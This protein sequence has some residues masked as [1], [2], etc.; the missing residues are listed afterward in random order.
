MTPIDRSGVNVSVRSTFGPSGR[1]FR[2]LERGSAK[3]YDD[4]RWVLLS[5]MLDD[6][7]T[8]RE[9]EIQEGNLPGFGLNV[10]GG[11]L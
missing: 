4:F 10:Q 5:L 6:D 9:D 1:W 11:N 7:G 2:V 8:D 3:H